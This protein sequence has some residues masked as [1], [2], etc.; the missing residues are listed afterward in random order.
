MTCCLLSG[1]KLDAQSLDPVP[2][3]SGSTPVAKTS[4][5][6]AK[7]Q[8]KLVK[9]SGVLGA[10]EAMTI[11]E[12]SIMV[13]LGYGEAEI[14]ADIRRKGLVKGATAAEINDLAGLGATPALLALLTDDNYILTDDEWG[15]YDIRRQ[16]RES[17]VKQSQKNEEVIIPTPTPYTE[18]PRRPLHIPLPHSIDVDHPVLSVPYSAF[19]QSSLDWAGGR[20]TPKIQPSRE[21]YEDRQQ[22]IGIFLQFLTTQS[23]LLK[24]YE[25]MFPQNSARIYEGEIAKCTNEIAALKYES[26]AI[27]KALSQMNEE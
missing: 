19:S 3:S 22:Q 8:G 9:P 6:V 12:V 1:K 20:K 14:I 13:R 25:S 10:D 24:R 16:Q 26:S 18:A 21:D 7:S 17:L 15:K 23:A 2:V 4:V 11:A 27:D 5:P